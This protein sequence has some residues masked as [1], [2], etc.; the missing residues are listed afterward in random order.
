MLQALNNT[1]KPRYFMPDG[2]TNKNLVAGG[3]ATAA[4]MDFQNRVAAWFATRILAAEHA[5]P[6]WG[7]PS[8]ST[9]EFVRCETEQPI[10]DIMVGDSEGRIAVV[11]VKHSLALEKGSESSFGKTMGQFVRQYLR[12][13]PAA[14]QKPA[15]WEKAL[16]PSRD[17]FVLITGSGSSARVISALP[18]IM[19]K[20]Q[21]LPGGA[22]VSAGPF[23]EDEKAVLSIVQ[24]HIQK[25]TQQACSTP[26]NDQQSRDLLSFVRVA[27]INVD[28]GG[29]AERE[30]KELLRQSILL[31]PE[32]AD[33]AWD[34]L[35]QAC[36]G[37]ARM[38][39]GGDR[40]QLQQLLTKGGICVKSTPS[41]R[42]DIQRL[43]AYSRDTIQSLAGYAE[44]RVGQ[45]ASIKIVRP[46][47]RVLGAA[48]ESTSLLV[49]G[50]PGAGKSGALHDLALSLQTGGHDVLV[51]AADRIQS[52]SLAAF[53]T[54]LQLDHDLDDVIEN[55]HGDGHA[56]VV[57]DALDAARSD[58][59]GKMLR[60]LLSRAMRIGGRWRVIASVRK[61]DLRYN[62]D[63]RTL[64]P[65]SAP[66]GYGD[67]GFANISH[68]LVPLLSQE[69]LREVGA[70]SEC[71]K[72]L[73][74]NVQS[75]P[76][77]E[78]REL[79]RVPFNLRLLGELIG[80]GLSVNTLTAISTQIELLNRYWE[81]RV[82]RQDQRGDAREA[83]LRKAASK[84]IASR[85]LR[86]MRPDVWQENDTSEI[87]SDLLSSRLL[88]EYQPFSGGTVDR[89]T[90]KF[91]HH[92]LFDYAAARLVFRVGVTELV[93]LV[94][95]DPE[96]VVAFRPSLAFHFQHLWEMDPS[97]HTP[98]WDLVFQFELERNIPLVGKIIGPTMAIDLL[99][100]LPDFEVLIQ[101]LQHELSM[102]GDCPTVRTIGHLS[103]ALMARTEH[104]RPLVGEGAPPWCDFAE[105]LSPFVASLS[106]PLRQLLILL[107]EQPKQLT[108][109]QK[110]AVGVAARKLLDYAWATK[111]NIGHW[112][113]SG[114]IQAVCRTFSSDRTASAAL[115]RRGLE[116]QHLQVHGHRELVDFSQEIAELAIQDP[117]LVRDI[118]LAAYQ[119]LQT[120]TETTSLGGT[121]QILRLTSTV[122][123]D[124]QQV[125]FMLTEVYPKFLDAAPA[126]ATSALIGALA[127]W[128]ER[129]HAPA[130]GKIVEDRIHF[131][132][133]N[134]TLRT[135]FSAI[136]DSGSD[137][138]GEYPLDMAS[139]WQTYLQTLLD[140]DGPL[141]ERILLLVAEQNAQAALWRRLLQSGAACPFTVGIR[142]RELLWESP[143][144]TSID[145][146][147]PAG[148]LL[149]AIFPSLRTEDRTSIEQRILAIPPRVDAGGRPNHYQRDRLVGCLAKDAMVTPAAISLR[150]QI[151]T[152]GGPPPNEPFFQTGGVEELEYTEVD[153]LK[154]L[155]VAVEE[156]A[157]RQM[158]ELFAPL[159]D[160]CREHLNSM[161]SAEATS[162]ILPGL[163]AAL[164]KSRTAEQDGVHPNEQALA[165]AYIVQTCASI[166]HRTPLPLQEQ[167]IILV[168][169][170]LLKAA[171]ACPDSSVPATSD[172]FDDF[173]SW[174][175]PIPLVDAAEGLLLLA[176]EDAWRSYAVINAVR[177]L[178]HAEDPAVRLQIAR[179]LNVWA[180]AVPEIMW[181]LF[182]MFGRSDP[183]RAVVRAALGSLS[184][185]ARREPARAIPI[186]EQISARIVDGHGA[187]GVREA[188]VTTFLGLYLWQGNADC[189]ARLQTIANA[190]WQYAVEA[191]SIVAGL[192][193]VLTFGR[194]DMTELEKDAVRRRA[195]ALT[196]TVLTVTATEFRRIA[197]ESNGKRRTDLDGILQ[198]RTR[199][200]CQL[201][202]SLSTQ[203]YFAS[204]AFNLRQT[205]PRP[206]PDRLQ[207]QRFLHEASTLFDTLATVGIAQ[208][209]YHLAETLESLLEFDPS[210]V[211]L[212]IRDTVLQAKSGAFEYD[213]LAA[214]VIVR[215]VQRFL[216][217]YRTQ[218]RDNPECRKALVQ[219]LDTFVSAGWPSARQLTYR[220]EEIFR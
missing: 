84:M 44:I 127:V 40:R 5:A 131:C 108:L 191:R 53:K 168:R 23:T 128:I 88:E 145:T 26:L 158:L 123:Q 208:V 136:W 189:E 55:W 48:A 214:G 148:Q 164:A 162:R 81:A 143:I 24:T 2:N 119:Q 101:R 41:Y 69:E 124:W 169:E 165:W 11:Q 147:E 38:R 207:R 209:A 7:W 33:A 10:D 4:G 96:L 220:L 186:I 1:M 135:D 54:E 32:Q 57:T 198:E 203:I 187:K 152:K 94:V 87:L 92:V 118:Y 200:L 219:I 211:F 167:E 27:E 195:L 213:S 86:V 166:A 218:L 43:L 98:F 112:L 125:L 190:P 160:F 71:M 159:R 133:L 36:A 117:V 35:V 6:L 102:A 52:S 179:N 201:L 212:K 75:S 104:S 103:G 29:A 171:E 90:L 60:E 182:E 66:T 78:L 217:E 9:L 181:E 115:L 176:R 100:N 12:P 116:P 63:L 111:G 97:G 30:A 132:G 142:L 83:I 215:I 3:A 21:A 70:Q 31:N 163:Q 82:I 65:G 157:N 72:R 202:D 196:T 13:N 68:F 39:G 120:S 56:F 45:G 144:L 67:P 114:G 199:V 73:V 46:S 197:T 93:Q 37:F 121:S 59:A 110:K 89:Y 74:E 206:V 106:S 34:I 140:S 146:S 137:H 204:G 79:I 109:N 194:A 170:I 184:L 210:G 17:R 151:E 130:S 188:C 183:S 192:R 126:E 141:L 185:I 154:R 153:H 42:D 8:N 172:A 25:A 155:G 95:S 15:P 18:A 174:S 58:H 80:E 180:A 64:F 134:T 51:L 107:C 16:D 85:S 178:S 150:S 149:K 19:G 76:N 129:E 49:I 47:T 138:A 20:I 22:Q 156:P 122:A 14:A 161:P 28:P 77:S 113:V 173:P 105:R 61:F 175:S 205:P 216:A 139:A 99:Q 50:D 91:P 177:R 193:D 62:Q